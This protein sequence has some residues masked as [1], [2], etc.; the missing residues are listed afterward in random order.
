MLNYSFAFGNQTMHLRHC[1]HVFA[2]LQAAILCTMMF[3][4]VLGTAPGDETCLL[5][6]HASDVDVL[7]DSFHYQSL[8]ST[9]W[10]ALDVDGNGITWT[11]GAGSPCQQ[12]CSSDASAANANDWLVTQ[13]ISKNVSSSVNT[14]PFNISLSVTVRTS[15]ASCTSKLLS[16]YNVQPK[17]VGLLFY[18]EVPVPLSGSAT[19][20]GACS[21]FSTTLTG[22]A[23][24][25]VISSQGQ[26]SS[27]E[28]CYCSPGYEYDAVTTQCTACVA[29][30]F[31][32][33]L[34]NNETCRVCPLNS[35]S[36]QS[37]AAVC[38]CNPGYLRPA[39]QP[40]Q[41]CIQPPSSPQ[42]SFSNSLYVTANSITPCW[43]PPSNPGGRPESLF[44]NIYIQ[45]IGTQSN[46]CLTKMSACITSAESS[47]SVSKAA[48][49]SI[50]FF[51]TLIVG[52]V[53]VVLAV[54]ATCFIIRKEAHHAPNPTS[55]TSE[56]KFTDLP[57]KK[58][59]PSH[60]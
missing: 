18:P 40:A 38:P 36:S 16:V 12:T 3:R 23:P 58:C 56:T 31:K 29:S 57:P 37:G 34:S 41:D 43:L 51:V 54:L 24:M 48:A 17:K 45:K 4:M 25:L 50:T 44:Y 52:A 7:M 22:N 32:S 28:Q 6:P 2:F 21:L 27:S 59:P 8:L 13:L 15:S 53:A 47:T 20:P 1:Q 33:A 10:N 49:I 42:V 30:K 60:M 14:Y 39:L 55:N 26:W 9:V 46:Q 35:M 5:Q 11:S 19:V